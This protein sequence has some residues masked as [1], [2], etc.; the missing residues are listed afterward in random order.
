M[1]YRLR[2]ADLALVVAILVD[3]MTLDILFVVEL[4]S[5]AASQMPMVLGR[6]LHFLVMDALVFGVKLRGFGTGNLAMLFA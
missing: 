6:I 3:L 1:I 5:F 4:F 2:R